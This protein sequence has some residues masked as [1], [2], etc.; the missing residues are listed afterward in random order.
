MA[1]TWIGTGKPS[2]EVKTTAGVSTVLIESTDIDYYPVYNRIGVTKL[3]EDVI[4]ANGCEN[5]YVAGHQYYGEIFYDYGMLTQAVI[6]KFKSIDEYDGDSGHD[7]YI[8]PRSD[9]AT[10]TGKCLIDI[11]ISYK[12]DRIKAGATV[13]ISWRLKELI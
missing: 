12:D 10:V 2:F 11:E 13:K 4:M 1:T 7:I 9:N 6:D 3:K 5:R 8:K